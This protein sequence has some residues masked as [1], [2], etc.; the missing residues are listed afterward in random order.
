MTDAPVEEYVPFWMRWPPNC[1]ETCGMSD[2]PENPFAVT[3]RWMVSLLVAAVFGLVGI[4]LAN[5]SVQIADV[6]S[7]NRIL[8]T[9]VSDL[10][11]SIQDL[12]NR[13]SSLVDT[14]NQCE[15]EWVQKE[16]Q[17][18]TEE[19]RTTRGRK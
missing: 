12:K 19:G 13:V 2:E 3:T 5:V 10:Q 14:L 16:Q 18:L 6:R 8:Q 15:A 17:S 7:D 11:L 4:V 9:K 1:C